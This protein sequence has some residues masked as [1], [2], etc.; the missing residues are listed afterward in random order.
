MPEDPTADQVSGWWR[1]PHP[2]A[3]LGAVLV[4][5]LIGG[6]AG[7]ASG[8][9]A[10]DQ[11][12]AD[13]D[14]AAAPGQ[15]SQVDRPSG[16]TL[17]PPGHAANPTACEPALSVVAAPDIAGVVREL[18]GSMTGGSCPRASVSAEEPA[19][20]LATLADGG[21]AP[22]VWIPASTLWLRVAAA[23]DGQDLPDIGTSIARTPVVIAF[24]QPVHDAIAGSGALPAW[25]MVYELATSGEIPRMSMADENT[26]VGALARVSL[27]EALLAS[28]NGDNGATF[29][30]TM[31][32]RDSLAS[33]DADAAALL[34][35][36]AGTSAARSGMSVGV[37]P[38]TEQQVLAYNDGGPPVP[39]HP[40]GTY[41]ASIEADYPMVIART[42][43]DRLT[44][45]AGDLHAR[46]RA[47]AAVQRLVE[48]GFRPPRGDSRPAA[49]ADP[50]RF[51][52]YPAP[53]ALPDAAGWRGLA[54]G[55]NWSG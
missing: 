37:F 5:S 28:N 21:A 47:P 45:I 35:T 17:P 14:G 51:P 33:T 1:R 7:W 4:L 38:A 53:V 11:D 31:R 32:F 52:D 55:W 46:L 34:T 29:V 2:A 8:A 13:P 15:P 30:E 25:T 49:L 22:D 50:G 41:D 24:P 48:A 27:N 42:L 19:A 44:G 9:P 6:V 3:V 54:D 12:A 23:S 18:A 36:L 39:V 26:T 43:D 20:T 40:M 10:G 16:H